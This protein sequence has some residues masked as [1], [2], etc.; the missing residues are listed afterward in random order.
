MDKKLVPIYLKMFCDYLHL[1]TRKDDFKEAKKKLYVHGADFEATIFFGSATNANSLESA[2]ALAAHLDEV[3]QDDFTAEAYDAVLGRLT[4]SRG[5]ILYSTTLYNHGWYKREVY[6]RYKLGDAEYEVINWDSVVC[7]GFSKAEWEDRKKKMPTWKF[8]MQ[9]RGIYDL[10]A[11]MIYNIFKDYVGEGGHLVKP[12]TIPQSWDWELAIDPGGVHTASG[13]FASNPDGKNYLVRSY[14]DGNMNTKE[15][16]AKAKRFLEFG[17]I[18]RAVGGS[19]SEGQFRIDW[20]AEGIHVREPEIR[21]VE[22]GIDKVLSLL[23]EG[24]FFIFDIPENQWIIEQFLTYSRQLNERGDPTERIHNKNEYHG[25]DMIRYWAVGKG[26]VGDY[27]TPYI[28]QHR[29]VPTFTN[30][31]I[32]SVIR[33]RAQPPKFR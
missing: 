7:P 9:Y 11:G 24:Q 18:K 14:L 16:V 27:S 3:G 26:N 22:S 20:T 5:R 23:K 15:H 2:T 12:F 4:R 28:S 33:E 31:S 10:P 29:N 8:N 13:W 30:P 21:D 1:S 17:R 32:S 6:D 25:M 19:G